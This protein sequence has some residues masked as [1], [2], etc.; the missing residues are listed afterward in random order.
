MKSVS[1]S[2]SVPASGL[3][4]GS[5][6]LVVLVLF[7]AACASKEK[8]CVAKPDYSRPTTGPALVRAAPH[9]IPDFRKVF[10]K[11]PAVLSALDESIAYF[12]KPS[13]QKYFP[14]QTVDSTITHEQ[15]LDG[16]ET[17]RKIIEISQT[18]DEFHGRIMGAF[19]V[20]RSVGWDGNGVVLFTGYYT[21]IFE[22][23][24]ARDAK[25][26]YPLYRRPADLVADENGKP[27]GR[28]TPEGQVVS[29]Y[30]RS[31]IEKNDILKG[32]ELVY[33]SD[34]FEVYVVHVQ[35]SAR[36][37]MPDGHEMH[38]GYAGKTDRAYKSVGMELINQGKLQKE[39]LSLARL[40]RYFREHPEEVDRMLGVNESYVFFAES[41][42]G[43]FG[44]IGARV[45]PYHSVATDKS[46]FPRGGAVVPSTTIPVATA[47]GDRLTFAP[48]V[49]LYFDQDTGGAISAA[50]R[51]D[52][53]MGTGD[54][55]E[56][57]AG[58]TYSEGK[59]FYLFLK[60]NPLRP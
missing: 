9:E 58:Y 44:S 23:S 32:Q 31:E 25:F 13:S 54:E 17:L 47:T 35:G 49:G 42:P 51:C 46:I 33:L 5:T 40:K 21:P 28:R 26:R 1:G 50:G 45:T 30:S 55:A 20:Y 60:P 8:C 4:G 11:D 14:Y 41:Q 19:D 15:Q 52:L 36:I 43:P 34:P 22:G 57:V 18:P 29:Y 2:R 10:S 56:R 53:Y 48:H 12:K 16:L 6:L 24:L 37:R 7:T 39:E 3:T 38:V 27:L 59:L